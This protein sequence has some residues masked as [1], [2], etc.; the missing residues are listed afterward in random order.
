MNNCP[1]MLHD[2]THNDLYMQIKE[3]AISKGLSLTMYDEGEINEMFSVVNASNDVCSDLKLFIGQLSEQ[4]PD[5]LFH[6]NE[7][8]V[9]FEEGGEFLVLYPCIYAGTKNVPYS[10]YNLAVYSW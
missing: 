3:W 10:R 2:V 8:D 6:D 9:L 1:V 5:T 4:Y 7:C